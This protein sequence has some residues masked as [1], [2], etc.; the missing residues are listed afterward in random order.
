MKT[1]ICY[2]TLIISIFVFYSCGQGNSTKNNETFGKIPSLVANFEMADSIHKAKA[3]SKVQTMKV[4][5]LKNYYEQFQKEEEDALTKLKLDAKAER[6]L[7][8]DKAVP[9]RVENENFE[10][11]GLKISDEEMNDGKGLKLFFTFVVK[12]PIELAPYSNG[13]LLKY[14]F[15]DDKG[16]EIEKEKQVT[17]ILGENYNTKV[18]QPGKEITQNFY[19]SLKNP[20]M[21]HFKEI[22]FY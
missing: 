18:V 12:K 10:V 14:K 11:K 8:K 2:F 6:D 3:E 9:F 1:K 5:E 20:S 13:Y 19:V 16:N 22:V 7:L 17:L 21:I 15:V 4:G